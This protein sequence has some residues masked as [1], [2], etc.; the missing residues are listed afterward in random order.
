MGH[1]FPLGWRYSPV[2]TIYQ[3][4]Y[5][6]ISL[7]IDTLWRMNGVL[8]LIHI[9][10]NFGK[11]RVSSPKPIWFL[12][13]LENSKILLLNCLQDNLSHVGIPED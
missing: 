8:L 10:W 1:L 12:R 6:F 4:N 7:S 13:I 5:F 2:I 3:S 9:F 11:F